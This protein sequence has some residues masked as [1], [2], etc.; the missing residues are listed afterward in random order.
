NSSSFG[1][2]IRLPV[3]VVRMRSTL[4]FIGAGADYKSRALFCAA[5]HAHQFDE[6]D[7]RHRR[8]NG[9]HSAEQPMLSPECVNDAPAPSTSNLSVG[10]AFA[11]NSTGLRISEACFSESALL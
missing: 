5:Q 10:S 7:A 8:C 11:I 4:R 9:L 3:C 1:G 2:R 6:C